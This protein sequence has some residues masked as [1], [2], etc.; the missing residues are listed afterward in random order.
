MIEHLCTI[1][2]KGDH[3]QITCRY[4]LMGMAYSEW[5]A[6]NMVKEYIRRMHRIRNAMKVREKYEGRGE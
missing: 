4:G 2:P 3:Y 6:E 1:V 5:G